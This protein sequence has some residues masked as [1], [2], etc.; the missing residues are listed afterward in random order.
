MLPYSSLLVCTILKI[1]LID[2]SLSVY[3]FDAQGCIQTEP[4]DI[5]DQLPILVLMMIILQRFSHHTWGLT[6]KDSS[7]VKI[8]DTAFRLAPSR[9]PFQVNGRRTSCAFAKY[10]EDMTNESMNS[11]SV[12]QDGKTHCTPASSTRHGNLDV[13]R[14][15]MPLFLKSTWTEWVRFPEFYMISLAYER[16]NTLLPEEFRRMV[17]DHIP[18]VIAAQQC[19]TVSTARFRLFLKFAGAFPHLS[20]ED[21]KKR[22]RVR[23][24][25]VMPRLQSVHKIE[26]SLF[27]NALWDSIRCKPFPIL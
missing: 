25:M 11:S 26:P 8:G 24:L 14:D 27:L 23:V 13:W 9:S 7:K 4:F 21:I 1:R 17:T 20:M 22:A 2:S 15:G 12:G 10:D 5:L 16:A 6:E 18:T 3:R 19:K